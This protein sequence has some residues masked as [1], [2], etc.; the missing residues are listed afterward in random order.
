MNAYKVL[1]EGIKHYTYEDPKCP[2]EWR[3]SGCYDI[4]V[5]E[6]YE[7]EAVAWCKE[8]SILNL[9][10]KEFNDME[11]IEILTCECVDSDDRDDE[12]LVDYN[13]KRKS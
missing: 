8:D 4:D 6:K 11:N 1:F 7:G 2:W 12:E 5:E 9:L 10:Y 13:L 3:G